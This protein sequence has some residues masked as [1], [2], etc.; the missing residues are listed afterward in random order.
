MTVDR[1]DPTPCDKCG[2]VHALCAA[3]RR[4]GLPCTQ[5]PLVGQRVCRMHGGRTP[6]ALAKGRENI[7]TARINAEVAELGW[8]PVTDPLSAF[9]EHV[10]EV[11]A[12]RDLCRQQLNALST[13]VG[14][15]KDEEELARAMVLVYER[16]LDRAG[17]QLV[18]M[19]KI[20][21]TA[22]ALGAARERPSRDQAEV[23]SR[24]LDHLVAGLDLSDDQR[25]RVP[26]ALASALRKEQLL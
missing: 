10:G 1:R 26:D 4:D 7:L 18:D 21:L 16:A 8:E 5:K 6:G 25:G 2:E 17:K 19:L 9:A 23:F 13:W 24:V 12:F 11:L 20:G 15:N 22:E 14:F 3:H